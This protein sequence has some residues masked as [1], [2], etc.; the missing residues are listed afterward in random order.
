MSDATKKCPMCAEMI[1]IEAKVCRF[2]GARFEVA[3]RGYCS[4]DHEM[5]DVDEYGKCKKC[6][7]DVI[8]MHVES[9]LLEEEKPTV[10]DTGEAV[11]WIV[12]PI[13][14]EGVNWRFNAVFLDAIFI[15]I[16]YIVIGVILGVLAEPASYASPEQIGSDLASIY[17]GVL[18]LLLLLIWP[19]YFILCETI[20]GKTLGKKFS[21]LCVIRKDGSRISWLQ[22][23]IRAFFSILEYN[24]LGAIVIWSTP[25]K[26]RIGD[27]I[28]GTL[29]VNRE[30]FY[31]IEYSQ[32]TTTFQFHDYRRI[33][34]A[35]I[36]DGVIHKLGMNRKLTLYGVSP[37]GNPIQMKWNTQ[38][39]RSQFERIRRELEDR[40]GVTFP[41]KIMIGR[42]VVALIFVLLI[43]IFTLALVATLFNNP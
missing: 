29:V 11:E 10:A 26:Q 3:R 18:L 16:V 40:S 12:E 28:A 6:G 19:L 34:F 32:D 30:K 31:R 9:R 36:T 5:V 41:E 1:Q 22:A 7:N 38:F 23:A 27:L 35:K 39:Q 21:Y 33:E 20:W 42:L 25:L 13:R 14:G 17:S 37:N 4:V 24:P 15:N 8:D 43:V 2:C